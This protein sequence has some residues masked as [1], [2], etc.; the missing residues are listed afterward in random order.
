MHETSVERTKGKTATPSHFRF[1]KKRALL[2]VTDM[3]N[4][5]IAMIAM[6]VLASSTR[7][8]SIPRNG[9]HEPDERNISA[10]KIGILMVITVARE[11]TTK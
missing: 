3:V 8:G 4:T 5:P 2:L 6:K 10:K 7:C 9:I 1:K 11:K